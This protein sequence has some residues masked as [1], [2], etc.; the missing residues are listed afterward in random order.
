MNGEIYC[1]GSVVTISELEGGG[2]RAS[3][4]SSTAENDF[5]NGVLGGSLWTTRDRIAPGGAV[6]QSRLYKQRG[7]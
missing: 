7:Q 4:S 3:I 2:G 1:N 6:G 5:A